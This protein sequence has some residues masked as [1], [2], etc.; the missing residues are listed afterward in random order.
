MST[1][2]GPSLLVTFVV[3]EDGELPR[4]FSETIAR[5]PLDVSGEP[6]SFD[7]L[8]DRVSRAIRLRRG[9]RP[10]PQPQ[11]A[12]KHEPETPDLTAEMIDTLERVGC[13]FFACEGPTL[14]PVDMVTC[15]VCALL[16]R[17][18]GRANERPHLNQPMVAKLRVCAA[19]ASPNWDGRVTIYPPEAAGL[20]A[21]IDRYA[22]NGS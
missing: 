10:T 18:R 21:F 11:P 17:L 1:E 19:D 5:V 9:R 22:S 12:T 20:I 8:I 16:A 7:S 4:A 3:T 2:D 6:S 13:Q 15:H 14:N